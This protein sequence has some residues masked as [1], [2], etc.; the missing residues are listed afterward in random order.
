MDI[1]AVCQGLASAASSITG[2]HCFDYLP[3]AVPEP[4]FYVGE[5]N[6]DYHQT[7]GGKISADVMCRVL[8]SRA[9]D[10]SAQRALRAYMQ[11]TGTYSI[12]AALEAARGAPG[13]PAL[14]GAADDLIVRRMQG[15]RFYLVG[16]T[17][18]LGAEWLVQVIG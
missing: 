3:D 11:N 15:H 8:V 18:Y 2:L 5:I 9:D 10:L 16:E 17:E 14:S 13:Q 7:A 12:R 1:D 4:C 6:I